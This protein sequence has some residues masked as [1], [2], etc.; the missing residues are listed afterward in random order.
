MDNILHVFREGEQEKQFRKRTNMLEDKLRI[1][2]KNI[3]ATVL[4]GFFFTFM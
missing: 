1:L 2:C 4:T 3:C